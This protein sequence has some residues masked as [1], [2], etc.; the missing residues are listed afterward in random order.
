MD[1]DEQG[2]QDEMTDTSDVVDEEYKSP[3]TMN[4]SSLGRHAQFAIDGLHY[5]LFWAAFPPV[6]G[7]FVEQQ[8]GSCEE[9]TAM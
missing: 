4:A 9:P 8:D 3:S 2:E 1:E 5:P 6:L 7:C